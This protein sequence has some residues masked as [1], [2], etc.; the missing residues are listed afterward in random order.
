[1]GQSSEGG[2]FL[3]PEQNSS[4]VEDL[5]GAE[6]GS[7]H[8]YLSLEEGYTDNLFNVDSNKSGSS[9]SR[10][11]PGIWFTLPRKKI[12]P[13]IITP[14]NASP[15]GLQLQIGDYEGTDRYE[16]YALAGAD[17]FF[18]PRILL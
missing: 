11:S 1:M 2:V 14:H 13:V 5:F 12:I 9:L 8:P 18:L 7:F 6:G 3:L 16:L 10:V 4:A 15:G 17:L